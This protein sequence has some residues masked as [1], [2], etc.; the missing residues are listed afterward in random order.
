M[1]D[2]PIPDLSAVAS[3]DRRPIEYTELNTASDPIG[4]G[5]NAIV[6]EATLTDNSPPD[7]VA[8]KEPSDL[9]T[10][11]FETVEQFLREAETWETVDRYEREKPRWAD[12]EHIVGVIDTG[13][14]LPW[15]VMEYMDGGSLRERLASQSNG[16][17]LNEA[18]WIG[19]CICRG[20]ELAHSYGIAHLDLK[21][22]NI[23]FRETPDGTWD[24][25]KIADWGLARLLAK[26]TGV[27]DGLSVEYAAPEQFN[28][29]EFGDPDTLTDI[30][31]IGTIVYT[32]VTGLP[33]HSGSQANIM[34]EVVDGENSALPS[35]IRNDCPPALDR[36]VEIAIAR[37]KVDRYRSITT[38]A[39][40]LEAIRT[41]KSLPPI[42]AR[43]V[44][45]EP[46]FG[47]R[48]IGATHQCSNG[49]SMFQGNPARTGYNSNANLPTQS[50]TTHWEFETSATVNDSP[51]VVG[52][53]VYVGS[54]DDQLFAVDASDGTQKWQIEVGGAAPP[55]VA[56][57]TVYAI[58]HNGNLYAIDARNG[59]QEWQFEVGDW[60]TSSP[61]VAGGTVY[62]G[63]TDNYLYAVDASDGTLHWQ[64]ETDDWVSSSPAVVDGTVYVG[65]DDNY[66]YAVDAN[67]GTQE[68]Q[69]EVGG[70]VFSSPAVA[71][72]TVYVGSA[73]N[74]LYAVDA[75]TGEEQ[76]CFKTGDW[77]ESSPAVANDTVFVGSN[78]NYL[79]AVDASDGTKQWHFETGDSVNSSPTVANGV[80][81]FGSR[82]KNLY[83][84][85]VSDGTQ[86]WRL[87][88]GIT[89]SL[90]VADD[91]IYV[92]VTT[93]GNYLY[94]LK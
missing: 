75:G 34:H 30:Y 68:W 45:V 73:D 42:V 89:N 2:S 22:A 82:D 36:A 44:D 8:L 41:G 13:D 61:A 65:S 91:T 62:F 6:Y 63:H 70:S 92:G 33:P 79:Y 59:T 90:A 35:S 57:G 72:G 23:L 93:N 64:F 5:G 37:S 86:Q 9:G 71:D 18:L 26:E 76:W 54:K 1:T 25:P 29:A 43:S 48:S 7:R 85:D 3:P 69:F 52:S 21:P 94:A 84:V 66:L 11:H 87:E 17:P 50:L 74:Y 77:V 56:D 38:F 60:G 81:Y 39:Q 14:E 20:V 32:L 58:G 55:A 67:Q 78:D 31:Q 80:V 53:T 40:A 24:V 49:W 16:L 27:I 19:E 88:N 46:A 83:A 47:G 15:I 12:S 28:S 10:L 51:A 4:T